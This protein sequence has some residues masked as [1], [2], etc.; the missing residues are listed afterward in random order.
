M[1]FI[2]LTRRKA[3]PSAH[4]GHFSQQGWGIGKTGNKQE[5]ECG[6]WVVTSREKGARVTVVAVT[7]NCSH[8]SESPVKIRS[9]SS[10]DW[11]KEMYPTFRGSLIT[12]I[13]I[14]TSTHK[15]PLSLHHTPYLSVRRTELVPWDLESRHRGEWVCLHAFHTHSSGFRP[16]SRPAPPPAC[17]RGRV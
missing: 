2:L 4:E 17:S 3:I 13:V 14:K 7:D 11:G 1:V 8:V 5:W 10:V 16:G 15:G 12:V 6:S 9:L